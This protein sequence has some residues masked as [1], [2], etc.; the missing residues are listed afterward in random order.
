M[1]KPRVRRHGAILPN[2]VIERVD[3]ISTMLG[4]SGDGSRKGLAVTRLLA[5]IMLIFFLSAILS[6]CGMLATHLESD[7]GGNGLVH[8]SD[9]HDFQKHDGT[10]VGSKIS[11]KVCGADISVSPAKPDAPMLIRTKVA[12]SF[13][14]IALVQAASVQPSSRFVRA[15]AGPGSTPPLQNF[16]LTQRLRL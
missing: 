3:A 15:R 2:C 4:L 12:A 14:S 11:F 1:G 10:A 13:G 16:D 6:P 5:K 7:H 9:S 8:A